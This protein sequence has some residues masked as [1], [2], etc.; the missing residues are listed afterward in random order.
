MELNSRQLKR[1]FPDN[2]V[3]QHC[4]A[5]LLVRQYSRYLPRRRV[6]EAMVANTSPWI[7]LALQA[8]HEVDIV[9]ATPDKL[10]KYI[11]KGSKQR[12]LSRAAAEL[13]RRAGGGAAARRVE[14]A[15]KAGHREVTATE[16]MFR[17]DPR[18]ALTA[19]S[20]GKV[21]RVAAFIGPGGQVA[22]TADK[23]RYSERPATLHHLSLCQFV[24]YY[25]LAGAEEVGRVHQQVAAAIPVIKA[26]DTDNPPLYHAHLPAVITLQGGQEMRRVQVPRVVDW[27]PDTHYARLAM[28]K[29]S[30]ICYKYYLLIK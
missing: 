7:L 8:N 16:A 30:I 1:T 24:Q 10:L 13:R 2:A 15:I 12:S 5:S 22:A 21:V 23:L 6:S 27:S 11:C 28:F 18:L 4:P 19:C 17:L 20:L 3:F 26:A 25:R 14:S 29:V 9:V